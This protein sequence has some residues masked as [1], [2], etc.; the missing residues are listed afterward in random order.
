M[1]GALGMPDAWRIL[2]S[3]TR[4]A[5]PGTKKPQGFDPW[6]SQNSISTGR[7]RL[8]L[9]HLLLSAILSDSQYQQQHFAAVGILFQKLQG[10]NVLGGLQQGDFLDSLDPHLQL[11]N[12]L[13]GLV[14]KA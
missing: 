7:Y 5:A 8:G 4:N 1:F 12:T 6:G 13:Y 11:M 9:H 2:Y 10:V 3:A 14:S